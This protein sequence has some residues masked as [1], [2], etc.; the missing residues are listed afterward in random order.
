LIADP[1]ALAPSISTGAI[2]DCCKP[3]SA[4]YRRRRSNWRRTLAEDS[5]RRQQPSPIA[6]R[7]DAD[8]LQVV[9]RQLG[10]HVP[11]DRVF[12]KGRRVLF[13]AQPPQPI[14][15]VH[16]VPRVSLPSAA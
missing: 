15:N 3:P 7:S 14:G 13:E 10:Q 1:P 8:L 5:N 9:C 11:I 6:D 4:P 12:V 2:N 16:G